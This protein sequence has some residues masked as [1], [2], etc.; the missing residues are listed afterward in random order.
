MDDLRL[1]GVDK[2]GR[3][4]VLTDASGKRY[5]L[6]IDDALRAAARHDTPRMG[7]LQIAVGGSI[8]P[9]EVQALIR[10]GLTADEVADRTGWNLDRILR[11]EGPVLDERR[12]VAD[13]AQQTAVDGYGATTLGQRVSE[14][15]VQR[16]VDPTTAQ[17]DAWRQDTGVWLVQCRFQ[18][19]G[20]D[21]QARWDFVSA[22]RTLTPRDDEARWLSEDSEAGT[23]LTGGVPVRAQTRVYDLE[24]EGGI[25]PRRQRRATEPVDLMTAMRERSKSRRGGRRPV[26]PSDV[27][28]GGLIPSDALPL[29][30][31]PY[32][33]GGQD[34]PP[35]AHPR[36]HAVEDPALEADAAAEWA[37]P[38]GADPAD[39]ADAGEV[40]FADG[41]SED[42]ALDE[43][44]LDDL[45]PQATDPVDEVGAAD[46]D[47]EDEWDD[48]DESQTAEAHEDPAA[49]GGTD[50]SARSTRRSR[51]TSVPSWDD[52][53][54]GTRSRPEQN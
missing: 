49:S 23:I 12:Y 17:W 19:G 45:D 51:R 6:A 24:A 40:H 44:A 13:L 52:I 27:P 42:V 50:D 54:F 1:V 35:A 38:D 18:A 9:R 41:E 5:G 11:Y 14:R 48:D 21:R 7:Q 10:S 31:L 25:T 3:R 43:F 36:P 26:S 22:T 30:P 46:L 39:A 53:V 28:G 16:E 15:M 29:E 8:R 47:V 32:E 20:R 33:P 37:V 34:L 2:D 4:L